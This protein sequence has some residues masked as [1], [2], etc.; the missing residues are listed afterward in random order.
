M[1]RGWLTGGSILLAALVIASPVMGEGWYGAFKPFIYSSDLNLFDNRSSSA[2]SANSLREDAKPAIDR[3][4]KAVSING[5]ELTIGR[6]FSKSSSAELTLT[7]LNP[8]ASTVPSLIGHS[9][10]LPTL[11]SG[12]LITA[13]VM[14]GFRRSLPESMEYDT[15][16]IG[17]EL[18]YRRQAAALWSFMGGFRY[19][20]LGEELDQSSPGK[21][22]LRSNTLFG[23]DA[24]SHFIGAQIG[25][26]FAASLRED[27]SINGEVKLG[28]FV[29]VVETTTLLFDNEGNTFSF[30]DGDTRIATLVEGNFSMDWLISPS[31]SL[32]AGYSAVFMGKVS[33]GAS[34][35]H[36]Q[37]AAGFKY[38]DT[39]NVLFHGPVLKFN[40]TW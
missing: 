23:V 30:K 9:K 38:N 1:K 8:D 25:A 15:E 4:S 3:P 19:M 12:N 40:F 39:D 37:T 32:S 6:R 5:A 36:D 34:I 26:D 27:L 10:S 33:D 20:Y 35:S 11:L 21:L 7:K 13:I 18:S 17:A 2:K 14:D 29:N 31:M 28:G 22:A 24:E 16:F